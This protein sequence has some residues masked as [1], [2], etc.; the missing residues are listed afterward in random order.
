VRLLGAVYGGL[1][2]DVGPRVAFAPS[3]AIGLVLDGPAIFA[4]E[5]TLS[6][7]WAASGT[8]ATALGQASLTLF[9]GAFTACPLR[10]GLGYGLALR[11]CAEIQLGELSASAS[12]PILSGPSTQSRPWIA[13]AALARAEWRVGPHFVVAAEGGAVFPL[14]YDRFYF[15]PNTDV[16]NVSAPAAEAKLGVGVVWP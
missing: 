14:L 4:P 12:A 5:L 6:G 16:Y 15:T 7:T 3:V 9:E 1:V 10:L 8:I 13:A 11:P 2:T